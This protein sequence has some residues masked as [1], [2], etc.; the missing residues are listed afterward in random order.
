M[1]SFGLVCLI[2]LILIFIAI[3]HAGVLLDY[4]NPS[5]LQVQLLGV[6]II[7]FGVIVLLAFEGSSGYGFTIGLT[8]V[9]RLIKLI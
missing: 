9:L 8:L 5:A 2:V 1:V 3:F 7:L 4:I 6:Q